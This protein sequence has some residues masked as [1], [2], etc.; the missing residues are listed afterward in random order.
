MILSPQLDYLFSRYSRGDDEAPDPRREESPVTCG[1]PKNSRLGGV[2]VLLFFTVVL[3]YEAY[4]KLAKI[5]DV[6]HEV[7][8]M[9]NKSF[10]KC[11]LR[12]YKTFS[13]NFLRADLPSGPFSL[14]SRE[15]KNHIL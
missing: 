2:S 8:T 1:Q 11:C 12:V 9:K 13:R 6:L 3:L 7:P 5:H 10:V 4:M 15:E 14:N